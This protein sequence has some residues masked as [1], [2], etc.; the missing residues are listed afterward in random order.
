MSPEV[1][2][3]DQLSAGATW[4]T[5]TT[6]KEEGWKGDGQDSFEKLLGLPWWLR[7]WELAM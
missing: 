5:A 7:S 1:Y 4:L 2:L 3:K 6:P